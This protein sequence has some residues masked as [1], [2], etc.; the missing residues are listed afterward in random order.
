MGRW[1]DGCY[2]QGG[3]PD[4]DGVC[5]NCETTDDCERGRYCNPDNGCCDATYAVECESNDDCPDWAYCNTFGYCDYDCLPED[6]C[7]GDACCAEDFC[8]DARGRCR[9]GACPDA[10]DEI[11][12]L[13]CE[14]CR[15]VLG[16]DWYCNVD[17]LVCKPGECCFDW[18]CDAEANGICDLHAGECIY[19]RAFVSLASLDG[20]KYLGQLA[21]GNL[22]RFKVISVDPGDSRLD[23]AL[24]YDRPAKPLKAGDLVVVGTRESVVHLAEIE[25]ILP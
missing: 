6:L 12:C 2:C 21:G 9:T 14:D 23:A 19:L 18:E 13:S 25:A 10:D 16:R 11:E 1:C 7:T 5:D 20:D 3:D 24:V 15:D 4:G 8:C 17:D 22:A